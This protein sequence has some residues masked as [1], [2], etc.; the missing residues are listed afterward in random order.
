MQ[1]QRGRNAHD[2]LKGAVF[3]GDGVGKKVGQGEMCNQIMSE[4]LGL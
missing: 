4:E 3:P 2:V 1:K